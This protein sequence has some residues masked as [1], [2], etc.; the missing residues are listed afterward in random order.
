MSPA[1]GTAADHPD[2][3]SDQLS[4]NTYTAG[5]PAIVPNSNGIRATPDPFISTGNAGHANV[6]LQ[7]RC[8]PTPYPYLA[9]TATAAAQVRLAAPRT[10]P[11]LTPEHA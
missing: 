6:E 1:R 4:P 10:S 5:L 7:L 3:R 9:S 2:V 8:W 11:T